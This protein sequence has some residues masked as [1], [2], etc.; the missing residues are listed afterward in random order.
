MIDDR[1]AAV[2]LITNS[3]LHT[4]GQTFVRAWPLDHSS[5]FGALLASIEE[6]AQ[7]LES[8]SPNGDG[9]AGTAQAN[10]C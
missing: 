2:G 5:T 8:E 7:A 3:D 6:A 4:L 1:V 10:A 9:I